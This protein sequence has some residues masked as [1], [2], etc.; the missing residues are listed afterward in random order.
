MKKTRVVVLILSLTILSSGILIVVHGGDSKQEPPPPQRPIPDEVVY[1]HLFSHV[2]AL[3]EKAEKAEKE[4]KDATQFRTHF[5]RKAK[6]SDEEVQTLNRVAEEWQQE[7]A[8]ID[9]R[10]K[11]VIQIYKAQFPGGQLPHGQTPPPPP[12]EL[13]T[14]SEQRDAAVLRARDRLKTAFGETEFNRFHG[15]VRDR[16]TPNV[17]L[18]Q[19]GAESSSQKAQQ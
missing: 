3:K 7:M 13:R 9:A 11:A 2:L 5:K 4:G 15:Y 1:K 16:V 18:I 12:P 14:L 6:L 10:A 8:P 19:P 17:Q